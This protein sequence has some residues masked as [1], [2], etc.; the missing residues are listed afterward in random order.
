MNI[1]YFGSLY[2]KITK[3]TFGAWFRGI[4]STCVT[5]QRKMNFIAIF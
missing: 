4:I 1:I 2:N 3:L 5:M